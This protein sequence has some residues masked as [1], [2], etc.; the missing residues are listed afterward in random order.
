MVASTAPASLCRRGV[1]GKNDN[2]HLYMGGLLVGAIETYE[3][4]PYSVSRG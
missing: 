4:A 2:V 1:G 3:C